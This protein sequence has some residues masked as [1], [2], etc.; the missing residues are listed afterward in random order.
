[1]KRAVDVLIILLLAPFWVL[2][3]TVV[4]L[5]VW[6]ALGRPVFFRQERSGLGGRSF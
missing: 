2:A 1:V 5:S 6:M 4:A 3:A